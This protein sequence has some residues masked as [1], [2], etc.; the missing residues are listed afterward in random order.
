MIFYVIFILKKF[1]TSSG[2]TESELDINGPNISEESAYR[3]TSIFQVSTQSRKLFC[4][5]NFSYQQTWNRIYT[6]CLFT[7]LLLLVIPIFYT[8]T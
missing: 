1:A 8:K 4:F 3:Y 2:L 6:F 5:L 7:N